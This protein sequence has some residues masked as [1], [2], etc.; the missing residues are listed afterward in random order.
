MGRH[1]PRGDAGA[2]ELERLA[3]QSLGIEVRLDRASWAPA[4]VF[5]LVGRLGGVAQGEL[6]RTLNMGVG[7]LALVAPEAADAAVRLLV[8]RGVPAWIAGQ[9]SAAMRAS[10]PTPDQLCW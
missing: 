3:V 10:A 1:R 7:M 5:E 2:A 6:E 9:A 4:P 8:D